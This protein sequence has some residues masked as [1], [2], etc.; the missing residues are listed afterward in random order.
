M[1]FAKEQL[2]LLLREWYMHPNGQVAAYEWAFGDVNPPVLAWAALKVYDLEAAHRPRRPPRA[3]RPRP[4][5]NA[6]ARMST[7]PSRSRSSAWERSGRATLRFTWPRRSPARRPV[8]SPRGPRWAALTIPFARE[9]SVRFSG[10]LAWL[11]WRA[12]Y[13]SKLPG[14]DRKVRVL[15]DWVIELFFPRDIVQTAEAG[16]PAP[17]VPA[18]PVPAQ[19]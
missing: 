12:I 13:L 10:L 5:G 19:G 4:R 18:S 14:L 15:A 17:P 9:R 11:L 6:P 8:C 1:D 7:R 16:E 2:V 3:V